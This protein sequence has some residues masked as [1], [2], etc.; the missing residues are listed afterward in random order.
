MYLLL[1]L[2]DISVAVVAGFRHIYIII[3]HC[4]TVV[5]ARIIYCF[6]LD[7]TSSLF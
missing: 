2:Y 6:A 3:L 4:I 1:I 7:F 5:S